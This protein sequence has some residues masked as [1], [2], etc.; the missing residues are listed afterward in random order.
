MVVSYFPISNQKITDRP[1][2]RS[3]VRLNGRNVSC[4]SCRSCFSPKIKI[5]SPL[6]FRLPWRDDAVVYLPACVYNGSGMQQPP[7][8]RTHT[9][10]HTHHHN[11]RNKVGNM[12]VRPP[13]R[14]SAR[15]FVEEQNNTNT[16]AHVFFSSPFQ[17]YFR[18]ILFQ[19]SLST[20]FTSAYC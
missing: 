6:L 5:P 19:T 17:L 12:S 14:P 13:V 10:T 16:N 8:K 1:L 2:V 20:F 7:T 3:L 4:V 18:R 11:H 15:L 9:H